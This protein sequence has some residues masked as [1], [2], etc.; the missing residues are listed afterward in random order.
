MAAEVRPAPAASELQEQDAPQ[1]PNGVAPPLTPPAGS[2]KELLSK[3]RDSSTVQKMEAMVRDL[4][5]H[6]PANEID[7]ARLID[8]KV[9]HLIKGR[10]MTLQ[11]AF[12]GWWIVKEHH[13][14]NRP[15]MAQL[16]N[17]YDNVTTEVKQ[18]VE[19]SVGAMRGEIEEIIENVAVRMEQAQ[20][21]V[22]LATANQLSQRVRKKIMLRAWRGFLLRKKKLADFGRRAGV[23]VGDQIERNVA[24]ALLH[25]TFR[26]WNRCRKSAKFSASDLTV[27][28]VFNISSILPR[29][30]YD[31]QGHQQGL[32]TNGNGYNGVTECL[33]DMGEMQKH[34]E[35][36]LVKTLR[37]YRTQMTELK[38]AFAQAQEEASLARQTRAATS[39]STQMSTAGSSQLRT[40]SGAYN[41]AAVAVVSED[42]AAPRVASL[43]FRMERLVT[44]ARRLLQENDMLSA[45]LQVTA[46]Q[47]DRVLGLK[48][49]AL[50][51]PDAASRAGEDSGSS[52]N[53]LD[54]AVIRERLALVENERDNLKVEIAELKQANGKQQQKARLD[55]LGMLQKLVDEKA[56]FGEEDNVVFQHCAGLLEQFA[57]GEAAEQEAADAAAGAGVGEAVEAL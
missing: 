50:S 35:R 46:K 57:E 39:Q 38:A 43:E 19:T 49:K 15:T 7:E 6:A 31:E 33:S 23:F 45:K 28:N 21:V 53:L 24:P 48:M 40:V 8:L 30:Y 2:G 42:P 41:A 20:H 47:R 13:G 52:A 3:L 29:R 37:T 17:L 12:I 55:F 56:A 36:I 1:M 16:Q 10:K 27:G 25:L 18:R 26:E 34:H 22:E 11:R 14:A 51:G 44:Y 54:E 32:G 4:R 5:Q 9:S